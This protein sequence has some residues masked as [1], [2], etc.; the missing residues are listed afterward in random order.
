MG[1]VAEDIRKQDKSAVSYNYKPWRG[2]GVES[3]RFYALR[4]SNNI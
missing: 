4:N 3:A 1:F 2:A